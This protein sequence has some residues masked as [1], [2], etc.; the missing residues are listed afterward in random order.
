[1]FLANQ[2]VPKAWEAAN[3]FIQIILK[4]INFPKCFHLNRSKKV[5]F[6][7]NH[8]AVKNF[9]TRSVLIQA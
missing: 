4:N 2:N 8:G 9:K 3:K 7:L 6:D 1:M 5:V